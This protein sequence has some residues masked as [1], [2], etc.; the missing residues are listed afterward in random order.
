MSGPLQVLS[1]V[2][3]SELT[4][5]AQRSRAHRPILVRSLHPR[6][7]LIGINPYRKS[8]QTSVHS[9]QVLAE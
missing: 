8:H 7:S 3:A 5:A 9:H 1:E 4:Y 6:D 2:C